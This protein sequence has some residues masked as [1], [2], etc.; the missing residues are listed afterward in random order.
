MNPQIEKEIQAGLAAAGCGIMRWKSPHG[1]AASVTAE[2]AA[3][4][5]AAPMLPK[6][7]DWLFVASE[8]G[9][10]PS[11]ALLIY[12]VSLRT[13]IGVMDIKSPR[14]AIH[15]VRARMIFMALARH[16]ANRTLPQIGN[17]CG[18]R[19]HSTVLHSLWKVETY[20]ERFQPELGE[21][22]AAF[23][24]GQEAPTS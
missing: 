20:P 8:G 4:A 15:I 13:G 18:G 3:Q 14:R 17:F 9:T 22:L 6:P 19:D 16:V 12:V 5:P 1:A 24:R 11:L 23:R 21:L 2:A 10:A 7:R